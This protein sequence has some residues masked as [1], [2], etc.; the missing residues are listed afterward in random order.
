MAISDAAWNGDSARFT[1]AQWRRSCLINRGGDENVKSNFSLPVRDPDGRLNRKGLAAAAGRLSQV[2][3]ISAD[4]R[5]TAA[6]QLIMLYHEAGLPVPDGLREIAK[7][8]A[9]RSVTLSGVER[10]STPVAVGLRDGNSRTI[11]GYAA[12]FDRESRM[13]PS[14]LGGAFVERVAPGFFD[15][16]RNAGWPGIQG[17]GVLCRF[18]HD[19]QSLLGTTRAVPPT[20]RLSVD[21]TGLEYCAD[22]PQCRDDVL[23]LIERGDIAQSSFTFADAQ[24]DW[25]YS[26]SGVTQRT[27]ISGQLLDVA[28][29]SAVA[30]YPETTVALRSLAAFKDVPEADVVALAQQHE[31]RKLF[32]RTDIAPPMSWQE[33]KLRLLSLRPHDPIRPGVRHVAPLAANPR[34]SSAARRMARLQAQRAAWH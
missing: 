9:S 2:E 30:A 4:Q 16:A 1:V 23:E 5:A 3:D 6:R 18:N 8:A 17:S 22:L 32:V 34:T 13:M 33:A 7:R 12:V 28:P 10:R 14:R 31:L 21:R 25:T 26:G 27:L 15:E 29:V 24:D 11:R 20:L 19:D